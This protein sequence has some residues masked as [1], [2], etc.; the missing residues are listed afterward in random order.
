LRGENREVFR[1]RVADA[2]DGHLALLHGFEESGLGARRSAVDFVHQEQVGENRA[3]ME[4]ESAVAK[5]EDVRSRDVGGHEVGGAL[6]T[7]ELETANACQAFDGESFGESGN[8]FHDGVS[9]TDENEQKLIDDLALA[10]DD[11]GKFSANV[12]CECGKVLHG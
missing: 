3:A 6:N 4:R 8:T 2:V 7:L 10:D 1:E 11:F 9:T 5:I 12:G